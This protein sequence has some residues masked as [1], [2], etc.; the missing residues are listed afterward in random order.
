MI[1][2]PPSDGAVQLRI[3]AFESP[4]AETPVGVP[5][6]PAESGVTAFDFADSSPSPVAF[7]ARTVKV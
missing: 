1:A 4:W 3:A 2:L 7:E 5:G 6:V